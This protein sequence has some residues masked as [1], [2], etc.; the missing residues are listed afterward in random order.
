M[1][2]LGHQPMPVVRGDV[3]GLQAFV[4]LHQVSPEAYNRIARPTWQK[5]APVIIGLPR[6]GVT[7]DAP[8]IAQILTDA[9]RCAPTEFVGAVRTIIR[10]ER[11]RIRTG[12]AT[13]TPPFLVL[14]D[15]DGCWSSPELN[16]AIYEELRDADNTPAE[17]AALLDVLKVGVAPAFDHALGCLSDSGPALRDRTLAI[18]EVLLRRAAVRAWPA[19]WATMVSD[20][21]LARELLLRV[22]ARFTLG[23]PLYAGI[24]ER[25]I[26]D[27]YVLTARLFPRNEDAE[28][29]MG[30]VTPFQAVGHLRDGIPRHL[31]DL[32]AQASVEALSGL[33]A[34]HPEFSGLAYELSRAEQIM[35]IATWEPLTS[36]EVLALTDKPDLQL[37]TTPADLCRVLVETLERYGA[38]LHGPQTPV[39]DL[40][41]RHGGKDI[42]RPIDEN[43]LSDV[44]IRFLRGALGGAGIF[45]NRE[46]EVGRAPGAPVGQRTDILVNAVR[47]RENGEQF[48]AIVAVIETKGCW[49]GELFTALEKQLFRDY[50][51]RLQAQVGVYLVGWFDITKWDTED[52]RR[53]RVPKMPVED[54]KERLD[55]QAAALPEGFVVQPVILECHVPA[56]PGPLRRKGSASSGRS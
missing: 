10:L 53:R 24:R 51:I 13:T 30:F 12:G 43:A 18:A 26:A 9:L 42:Y 8:D 56:S 32:G 44:I 19:L 46:V 1:I 49:N 28:R 25:E 20:D 14:L 35:R 5:W 2:W 7:D 40:W 34:N 45:A 3:A 41:D 23:T 36:K 33:I 22:A 54:A 31:A 16:A 55:A 29:V 37:V 47:R 11:E 6:H 17:Y 52:G 50:M 21:D 27:L 48:D 39:R 38:A 4:L 15:L